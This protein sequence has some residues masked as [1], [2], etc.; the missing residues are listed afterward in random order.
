MSQQPSPASKLITPTI[1]RVQ[2]MKD[3]LIITYKLDEKRALTPNNS[4][5]R[6]VPIA[7]LKEKLRKKV[8]TLYMKTKNKQR[9]SS[10]TEESDIRTIIYHS[11][12]SDPNTTV[13]TQTESASSASSF[14][15]GSSIT[16][17]TDTTRPNRTCT[18]SVSD[19]STAISSV[20]TRTT[21]QA[22]LSGHA[23]QLN[24]LSGSAP[25]YNLQTVQ[26]P[27]YISE[28]D[29]EDEINTN[30]SSY[31]P[32]CRTPDNKK[33]KEVAPHSKRT[34]SNKSKIVSSYNSMRAQYVSSIGVTDDDD[35]YAHLTVST[36]LTENCNPFGA[37]PMR[38]C[39]TP[40]YS[41]DGCGDD[42]AEYPELLQF[43][44]SLQ[45][46]PPQHSFNYFFIEHEE[47]YSNRSSDSTQSTHI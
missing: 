30:A 8:E 42:S 40:I 20:P 29:D 9:S 44:R 36:Q 10:H 39:N 12:S 32:S 23:L 11:S 24:Q 19:L 28:S 6:K 25:M 7:M 18:E 15:C 5:E 27:F 2:I 16:K 35:Y 38:N 31:Y 33:M 46:Q 21:L 1:D 14:G 26:N 17:L 4:V 37:H 3:E 34:N 43:Q 41:S 47:E 13:M 22:V 45:Q